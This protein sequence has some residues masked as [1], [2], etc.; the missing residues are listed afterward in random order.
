MFL[1][2]QQRVGFCQARHMD[3]SRGLPP[4]PRSQTSYFLDAIV[5]TVGLRCGKTDA[6]APSPS[7]ALDSAFP[8]INGKR[9]GLFPIAE[10][11]VGLATPS[12]FSLTWLQG[13]SISP[14]GTHVIPAQ[15][16]Y[17]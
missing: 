15:D 4:P 11:S 14:A 7:F 12:K 8:H 2:A 1:F 3:S 13:R 16:I 17:S 9:S 10:D 6:V 5:R